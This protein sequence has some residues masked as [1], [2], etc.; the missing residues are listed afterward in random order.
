MNPGFNLML[1]GFFTTMG[2]PLIKGRDFSDADRVGSPLVAIVN[3]TSVK[4]FVPSGTPI[5]LH[6]GWMGSGPMPFRIIGVVKDMKGSNLKEE[7]KPWTYLPALQSEK[8]WGM[9]YYVR[10]SGDPK[11]LERMIVKTVAQF[12]PTLPVFDMRTLEDQIDRTQFMDRL[13]SWLAAA[14]GILATVLALIGLY[15]VTSY[16]VARRRQEI[17]IR[18]ALGAQQ[19]S[20]FSMVMREVLVVC[21][22]GLVAGIPFA[23][24]LGRLVSHQLF[25]V[26]PDDPWAF[27]APVVAIVIVSATAGFLP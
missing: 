6:F 21:A 10:T 14:F 5:G 16:S 3:E 22:V 9:T 18:M 24:W 23:F 15:G 26:K 12:D 4:R 17:G 20:I 11:S 19:Q 2:V 13:F 25:G 8:P 1:P 27:A 7:P